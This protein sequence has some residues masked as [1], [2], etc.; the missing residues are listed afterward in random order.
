[1]M[2]VGIGGEGLIEFSMIFNAFIGRDDLRLGDI[3]MKLIG[4]A[5]LPMNGPLRYGGIKDNYSD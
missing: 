2:K 1:M 3:L 4:E 5:I